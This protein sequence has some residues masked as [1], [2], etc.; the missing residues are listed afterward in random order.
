MNLNGLSS[1]NHASPAAVPAVSTADSESRSLQNQITSAQQRLNHLSSDEEITSEEKAKE[2]QE[3]QKQIAE[4]NR[5]LRQHRLEQKEEV[6]ETA[7]EVQK[8]ELLQEERLEE[9]KTEAESRKNPFDKP[10][11]EENTGLA[12]D[13]I[14][15]MFAT[16][17]LLQQGRVRESMERRTEGQEN[18]LEAEI[19]SDSI[20]GTNT[21]AK[22]EKLSAMR[23]EN[24]FEIEEL[25]TD[26][27]PNSQGTLSNA[28]III[29]E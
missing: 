29:T 14:Q 15:K 20:Y 17:S 9:N 25:T 2:R 22:E 18:I 12:A 28:K 7:Q 10:Q 8:K 19:R 1:Y 13:N 23:K 21:T 4:L 3:L 11:E 26:P 24:G 6:K 5:K 27:E 16:G